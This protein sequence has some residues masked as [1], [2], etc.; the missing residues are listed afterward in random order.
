MDVTF[1]LSQRWHKVK[2]QFKVL[3]SGCNVASISYLVARGRYF[4]RSS[5]FCRWGSELCGILDDSRMIRSIRRFH[6][7]PN[8]AD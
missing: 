6:D 5:C 4:T 3:L 7:M 8:R 1:N 2:T